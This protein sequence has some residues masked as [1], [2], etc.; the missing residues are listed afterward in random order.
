[1]HNK[2]I[3]IIDDDH[4]LAQLL[5]DYLT[6]YNF[7][8]SCCFDGQSGLEQ[9]LEGDFD[10]ILLDIMMPKLNGFEV[11]KALGPM[12][13]TPILMLTAKGD[14]NDK[15]LG[16]ELGADDYLPKPFHHQELLARINAILRRINLIEAQ[17]T[18]NNK[19]ALSLSINDICIEHNT[20]QV[21]CQKNELILTSTEYHV[22]TILMQQEGTIVSKA[23]LSE[24]VLGRKLAPFDRSIDVHVS[25]IRRK[26]LPYCDDEK[27]K[28]IRG[29]GYLFITGD[30]G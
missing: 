6:A 10:M 12:F 30:Q 4:D 25:N 17:Y 7:D 16:L 1:M 28:T 22:L 15:V 13:E 23:C 24:E 8:I 18:T 9:A 21:T 27:I 20:R 19:K 26:L 11:L 14:N 5:K 29:A 2:R 3:L